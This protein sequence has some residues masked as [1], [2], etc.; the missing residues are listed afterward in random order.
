MDPHDNSPVT[1][2][3]ADLV[4]FLTERGRVEVDLALARLQ[5]AHLQSENERLKTLPGG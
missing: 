4:P 1:P 2:T 5:V 3:L